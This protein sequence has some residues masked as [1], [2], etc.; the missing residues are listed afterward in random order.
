[1]IKKGILKEKY[2]EVYRDPY[3]NRNFSKTKALPLTE[4]QKRAIAPV[5]SAIE[6]HRHEIFLLYG[7]TGSGKTEIYLQAIETS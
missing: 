7:V 5:L 3:D 2:V 1:M 6:G 4:E